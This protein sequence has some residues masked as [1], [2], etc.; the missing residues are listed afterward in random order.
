MT[1]LKERIEKLEK[2]IDE[3]TFVVCELVKEINSYIQKETNYIEEARE[4]L[5]RLNS[6]LEAS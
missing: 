5:K 6:S 1:D 2:K 3:H 4:E